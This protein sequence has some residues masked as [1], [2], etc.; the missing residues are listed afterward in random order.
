MK[1]SPVGPLAVGVKARDEMAV[2]P[3]VTSLMGATGAPA[4]TAKLNE[5]SVT[6]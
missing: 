4:G 3:A 6:F 5:E 1:R 2:P